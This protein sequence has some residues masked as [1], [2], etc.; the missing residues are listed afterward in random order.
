MALKRALTVSNILNKKRD[1]LPFDGEWLEAIGCPELRGS[2]LVW[3]GSG[4]GKT[5]FVMLLCKY[6]SR[7]GRVVYDSLE[8]G[9]SESIRMALLRTDM[10]EVGSR[11]LFLDRESIVELR[12]RLSRRNAPRVVVV[13]SV[14]YSG[15]SYTGYQK[16]LEDFPETLFILISHAEGKAPAGR[17][18]TRMRYD[19]MVKIRV[20]GYRA[21]CISR[22]RT[23]EG[24]PIT[25]W[26]EGAE[27][28]QAV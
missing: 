7:F 19:A 9:D 15:L 12:E 28:Y 10:R 4:S 16:L 25:I 23:G 1:L 22:Y 8:E 3:G 13:D 6:L 17:T 24:T 18:A 14:Q 11:V 20:E 5:T 2:W 26:A 27:K 21:Y